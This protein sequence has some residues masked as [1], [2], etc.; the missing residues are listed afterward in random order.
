MGVILMPLLSIALRD[1]M[2]RAGP[3]KVML[4]ALRLGTCSR[5]VAVMLPLLSIV[6][7]FRN[8][9]EIPNIARLRLS[10]V[11]R[12]LS[13]RSIRVQ[14]QKLSLKEMLTGIIPPVRLHNL[15]G[16]I[17]N[18][19]HVFNHTVLHRIPNQGRVRSIQLQN[20]AI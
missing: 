8:Q 17:H 12:T 4:Q 1:K 6:K 15:L 18:L 13:S 7:K 3:P 19:E 20:T 10:P 9:A 2:L 11:T 5:A 16:H 14:I